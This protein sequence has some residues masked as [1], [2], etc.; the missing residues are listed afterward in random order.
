MWC[1]L[2]LSPKSQY[3]LQTKNKGMLRTWIVLHHS[4]YWQ[5]AQNKTDMTSWKLA[6][7]TMWRQCYTELK[8]CWTYLLKGNGAFLNK[9][10]VVLSLKGVLK[11]IMVKMHSAR[12]LAIWARM[13]KS[14]LIEGLDYHNKLSLLFLIRL[15][16]LLV[17]FT[18][19]LL[20]RVEDPCQ[21]AKSVSMHMDSSSPY[22][23]DV[24]H[25]LSLCLSLL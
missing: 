11:T 12:K 16:W 14:H 18:P 10:C 1:L 25:T 5:I 24:G 19:V 17:C 9:L 6:I 8:R 23:M 4:N 3:I 22:A 13:T 21:S 20:Q 2:E 15:C 7:F